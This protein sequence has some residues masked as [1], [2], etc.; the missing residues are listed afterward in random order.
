LIDFIVN[1]ASHYFVN[2]FKLEKNK[3]LEVQ[4]KLKSFLI[5]GNQSWIQQYPYNYFVNKNSINDN[6]VLLHLRYRGVIELGLSLN[7]KDMSKLD[8]LV[9]WKN[10]K[11]ISN[12]IKK[13]P[14]EINSLTC[15]G[16]YGAVITN[17]TAV[18]GYGEIGTLPGLPVMEGKCVLFKVL[19]GT[20]F[21]P[22]CIEEKNA[23]K[24]IDIVKRIS[25]SFSAINLE[26]IKSPECFEI[27]STL[28]QN[29]SYPVFHDDQHGTAVVVVAGI[30]NALKLA[31]KKIEDIKIVM[32]GAGAA[33]L[34]VTELLITCGAK[35]VII[36]DTNGAIYAGRSKGMNYFKE[37][38]A[39][40]TNKEKESGNLEIVLRNADVF[41]GVSAPGTLTQQ[42]IKTMN[43]D[44]IIFALANPVPEI[45]PHEAKAAGAL[46]VATGRSDFKNQV[47]NSMA[48]PGIFRAAIDTRARKISIQ[49][50]IAACYAIANLIND[51]LLSADYIIPD[52]LDTRVP[53]AVAKAVALEAIK[54]GLATNIKYDE[55]HVEDS[56]VGWL[57]EDKIRNWDEIE[58]TKLE[59]F[60]NSLKSKF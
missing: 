3:I 36:C 8:E 56:L 33:G 34:S 13:N 7:I 14:N 24:F 49:M 28:I 51:E 55:S 23:K 10:L 39:S 1:K 17:G 50:K 18:L 38:L 11:H 12:L 25:P 52:S 40:L 5:E 35:K 44:P 53:V 6:A 46:V 37:K 43:K 41:I 48:F 29:I 45:L 4:N 47:N 19:G 42:M 60:T 30:I 57:L 54:S 26:D 31:K 21:I 9:S 58:K 22:L 32:N 20:N 59:F 2:N 16:N 15:K 27:E